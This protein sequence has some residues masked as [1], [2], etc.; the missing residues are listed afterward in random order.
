MLKRL[1]S[2]LA[3]AAGAF[4]A[5]P[6]PAQTPRS[7]GELVFPVPS[8]PPSYD[9]HREETFGLIHPF[10]PFYNTLVRVDP[11]DK[12]GTK[13]YPSLGE[14]WTRAT[15][16]V[17]SHSGSRSAMTMRRPPRVMRR[18]SIASAGPS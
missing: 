15:E 5:F 7:G 16:T 13:P 4:L 17:S 10:A 6:L 2:L 18:R 14:S 8:E 3:L 11:F 9:G 12:G 1:A